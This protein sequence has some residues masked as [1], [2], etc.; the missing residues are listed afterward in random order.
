MIDMNI[1]YFRKRLSVTQEQLAEQLNV[2]RQ[3]VAKW[4]NAEVTPNINDCVKMSEIFQVSVDD[5]VKNME[6]KELPLVSPKGKHLFGIV[7]VGERGQM[8]IPKEARE[9]FRIKAGDKL[10]VLGDEGQ[11]IAIVKM[12]A[13]QS[14]AKH[15]LKVLNSKGEDLR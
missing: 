3:T 14:F 4:E 5:L 6:E 9:V 1:R 7:T 15:I 13:F 10:L 2:S 11:G 8:V 12:D